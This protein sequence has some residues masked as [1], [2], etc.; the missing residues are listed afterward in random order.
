MVVTGISGVHD[1]MRAVEVQVSQ[2]ATRR[3][4]GTSAGSHITLLNGFR[5]QCGG[6]TVRVPLST[7]RVLAFL[8]LHDCDL[9]RAH[10]ANVL[11]PDTSEQRA[12]A[13]LRSALWRLGGYRLAFTES[14]ARILCLAAT[15]DVD[16]RQM[17]QLSL[18]I[19]DQ[20]SYEA[21]EAESLIRSGELLPG[22][23]DE[24]LLAERE[25][26]RQLRLHALEALCER[27]TAIGRYSGAIAAGLAAVAGEPLRE[28]AQLILIKAYVAEG[29]RAEAVRQFERYRDVLRAELGLEPSP[30]LQSDLVFPTSTAPMRTP[31]GKTQRRGRD[32]PLVAVTWLS[33]VMHLC[34]D[35]LADFTAPVSPWW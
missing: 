9:L 20:T 29:N 16:V 5:L 2:T 11:W 12:A 13:N 35:Y 17:E 32:L 8:A 15:V 6:R 27:W 4:A 21:T 31:T 28:S 25:R 14:N 23:Y 10:V 24:W 34:G 7:Q 26:L 30:E 18:R 3:A 19:L 22:F 1:D 33:P